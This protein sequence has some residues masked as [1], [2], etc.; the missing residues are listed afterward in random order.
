MSLLYDSMEPFVILDKTTVSDG[1]GGVKT[2]Y[3]DGAPIEAALS[4]EDTTEARVAAVEGAKD[5]FKI[6][7]KKNVVLR[8]HDVVRREKNGKVYRIT[9]NGDDYATPEAAA[10]DARAVNAEE[11]EVIN[12]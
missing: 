2:V 11:Y 3:V 9:T 5:R 6:I 12:G 1:Y 10:L 8:F 7:T 4:F